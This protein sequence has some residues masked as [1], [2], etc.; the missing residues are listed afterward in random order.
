MMEKLDTAASATMPI[1]I[2]VSGLTFLGVTMQ[3][4]VFIGTGLLIAFQLI[5]ICPKVARTIRALFNK[6]KPK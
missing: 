3:D 6:E 5:V 4:W 2:G 1:P